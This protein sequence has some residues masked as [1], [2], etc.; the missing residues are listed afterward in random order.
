M[1]TV[2]LSPDRA[3][4]LVY[5]ESVLESGQ[6]VF[7]GIYVISFK[8]NKLTDLIGL[9]Q[10]SYEWNTPDLEESDRHWPGNLD[11]ADVIASLNELYSNE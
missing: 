5:T 8:Q 10:E 4:M 2:Y 3:N 11:P 1:K 6:S 7:P 9:D